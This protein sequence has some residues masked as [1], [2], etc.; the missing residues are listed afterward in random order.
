MAVSNG[1]GLVPVFD[2]G[3]GGSS[4]AS[5]LGSGGSA[6]FGVT[7]GGVTF[8]GVETAL[9]GLASEGWGF[10]RATAFSVALGGSAGFGTTGG[11]VTFGG[12]ETAL[13]GLASS[14]WGF[15]GATGRGA[16]DSPVG[17]GV[18]VAG[19]TSATPSGGCGL[20]FHGFQTAT[21][22]PRPSTATTTAASTADR[23]R[24]L[25]SAGSGTGITGWVGWATTTGA[26]P[27]G[28]VGASEK[29]WASAPT[30]SQQLVKRSEGV[31]A[32]AFAST[33]STPRGRAAFLLHGGGGAS[34]TIL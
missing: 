29:D 22:P 24:L 13:A 6:G 18:A 33:A 3:G 16:T 17:T 19:L 20:R 32:R 11:G 27:T 8:G 15:G 25:G 7:G 5:S 1:V 26:G 21:A 14:G 23:E 4:S 31:L 30:N 12:V 2:S 9:A 28:A 34:L 10:G